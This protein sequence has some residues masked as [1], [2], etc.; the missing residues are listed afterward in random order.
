MA[1]HEFRDDDSGYATSLSTHRAGY[2]LKIAASP[3][4]A[5]AKVHHSRCS[6]IAPCDGKSATGSYRKVRA[7][8]L[9]ELERWAAE[10]AHPLP[11]ACRSCHR[12]RPARPAAA[13]RRHVRAPLPEGR[14]RAEGPTLQCRA[15]QAWADDY[16]RY[17]AARPPWQHDLRNDLRTLLRKLKP[18]AGRRSCTPRSSAT[19][20]TT[21]TSKTSCCT[22]STPSKQR[23]RT[24]SASNKAPTFHLPVTAPTIRSNTA[25]SYNQHRRAFTDGMQ[26]AS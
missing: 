23:E 21:R 16:L 18:S 10:H 17:G 5:E 1:V 25:T 3:S 4:P 11:S 7:V 14:A 9:A 22:T 6:H 20:P 26:C 12:G 15:V 13:V 8:E 19:N 2:L 24:E